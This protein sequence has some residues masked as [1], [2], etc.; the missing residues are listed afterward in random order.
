MNSGFGGAEHLQHLWHRW[1]SVHTASA[2]LCQKHLSI[3]KMHARLRIQPNL[4]GRASLPTLCQIA[5]FLVQLQAQNMA[6]Q[7]R[8]LKYLKIYEHLMNIETVNALII[9]HG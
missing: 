6:L 7:V 4:Q 2:S 3:T 8:T 5:S 1:S 9:Q